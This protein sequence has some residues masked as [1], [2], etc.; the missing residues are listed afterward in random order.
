LGGVDAN[1]GHHAEDR[2]DLANAVMNHPN[3]V[4]GT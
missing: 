3:G 1:S 4:A 2:A